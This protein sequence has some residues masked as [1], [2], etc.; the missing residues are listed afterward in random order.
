MDLL[1][2]EGLVEALEQAELSRCAVLDADVLEVR[3]DEAGEAVRGEGRAVVGDEERPRLQRTTNALRFL[4]GLIE[5][6]PGRVRGVGWRQV[7]RQ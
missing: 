6:R 1:G 4:D 5:R 2:L 7:G 3:L